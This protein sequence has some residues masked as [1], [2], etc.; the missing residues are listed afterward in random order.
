MKKIIGMLLFL[1]VL[2]FGLTKDQ[3]VGTWMTYIGGTKTKLTLR[4]D[5]TASYHS[6]A[7]GKSYLAR[8]LNDG[9]NNLRIHIYGDRKFFL[10]DDPAVALILIVNGGKLSGI[11]KD[12]FRKTGTHFTVT[13]TKEGYV[14]NRV[15]QTK[16]GT[17]SKSLNK[18]MSKKSKNT[19]NTSG[20]YIASYCV[21]TSRDKNNMYFSN[22]CNHNIFISYCD[23]SKPITGK[24]CGDYKGSNATSNGTYYTHSRNLE[25]G[26]KFSK[27]KP[28]SIR[29][30]ACKGMTGF[31]KGIVDRSDGS[32][33]CPE[34]KRLY[35]R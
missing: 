26:K 4:I 29:F 16:I 1:S 21:K 28:G 24:R 8:W 11:Q 22:T 32:Y 7:R 17:K 9:G 25:A 35:S 13:G 10:A 23:E 6:Y 27:Y 14:D 30:A 18:S 33:T 19:I 34:P 5:Y 15:N 31:G 20:D 12:I 2:A 3:V